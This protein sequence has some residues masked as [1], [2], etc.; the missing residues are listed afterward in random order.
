MTHEKRRPLNSLREVP[1]GDGAGDDHVLAGL[2]ELHEPEK[3]EQLVEA[4]PLEEGRLGVG[5][6]AGLAVL[7]GVAGRLDEGQAQGPAHHDDR[8]GQ[9]GLQYECRI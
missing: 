3:A 5:D 9:A 8:H 6:E 1:R 7:V 4:G 2:G